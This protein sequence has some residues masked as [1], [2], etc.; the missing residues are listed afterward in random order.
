M[1]MPWLA[2]NVS[3]HAM[4]LPWPSAEEAYQLAKCYR[5]LTISK[6]RK[7]NQMNCWKTS[8][9]AK[10]EILSQKKRKAVSNSPLTL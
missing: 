10:A 2:L 6:M 8:E 9:A 3:W 5:N 1:A 4:A 7:A